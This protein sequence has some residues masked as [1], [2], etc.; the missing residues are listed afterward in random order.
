M[1]YRG[2]SLF[3]TSLLFL[4]AEYVRQ[5]WQEDEFFGYQF[6]NGLNPMV[7]EKCTKLPKNFS[8]TEDMVKSFLPSV[9]SLQKEMEV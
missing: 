2:S 9:S 3:L 6:L 8:V 7:I 1:T 5:H 4:I